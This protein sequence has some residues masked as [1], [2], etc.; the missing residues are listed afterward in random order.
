MVK[1]GHLETG[2]KGAAVAATSVRNDMQRRQRGRAWR[3]EEVSKKYR[4]GGQGEGAEIV[5]CGKG[6]ESGGRRQE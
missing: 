3:K 4:G 1:S 6:Q 2:G 5:A